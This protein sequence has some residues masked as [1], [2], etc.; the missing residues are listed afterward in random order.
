MNI[1]LD[2]F[3]TLLTGVKVQVTQD[4]EPQAECVDVIELYS[5]VLGVPR[6]TGNAEDI[7]NQPG[8]AFDQIPNEP[9]NFPSKG[10]I[11]VMNSKFNGTVGH[12]GI[13]TGIADEMTFEM[14]EQNDPL[15]SDCHKKTYAYANGSGEIVV[16]GWLH[17]K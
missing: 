5:R 17:K 2:D 3:I 9:T 7:Y 4:N 12:V 6:F 14:L 11:V 13:C 15:G 8:D 10:D 1:S 16:T